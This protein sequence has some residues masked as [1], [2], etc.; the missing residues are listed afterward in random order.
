MSPRPAPA[1]TA[2]GIV[3]ALSALA[4]ASSASS[5]CPPYPPSPAVLSVDFDSKSHRQ[6]AGGSDN[7]AITWHS[8]GHQYA[9]FGDGGGFGGSNT[10]GRVSLGVARIEGPYAAWAGHNVW[11]GRNPENPATFTGKSRGIL[12]IGPDLW[13]WRTPSSNV[14]GYESNTLARS[15]DDSTTWSLLPW[16]LGDGLVTMPTFLQFGQAYSGARDSYV[17]TYA[18]ELE[19][20]SALAVQKPGKIMLLRAPVDDLASRASWEWF[21]GTSASP[22]WS[23]SSSD[24]RPVFE[25][26]NGVGWTVSVSFNPALDRYVLVTEHTRSFAGRLGMFDAPEPW[27]PWTTVAYYNTPWEGQSD[28]FFWN[29]SQ[30]WADGLDFVLV[31]TGIASNDAWQTV[32]GSFVLRSIH[33]DGFESGRPSAWSSQP[34]HVR[35]RRPRCSPEPSPRSNLAHQ[36]ER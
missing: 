4:A 33:D 26:P 34:G 23:R 18:V 6:M 32:T 12:S 31:Y 3:V 1:P 19:D 16:T 24:R 27:G 17:Y 25:D 20:T 11:G 22:R 7:W 8:D 15:T 29:F 5:Q 14:A 2:V 21:A 35:A 36:A 30:K 28:T 13:M 10:S 9:A